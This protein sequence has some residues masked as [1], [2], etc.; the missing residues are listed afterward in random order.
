VIKSKQEEEKKEPEVIKPT[1]TSIVDKK[2]EEPK[3]LQISDVFKAQPKQDPFP[4][5]P[6]KPE[7]KKIGANPF[8]KKEED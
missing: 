7:P 5:K 4:K 3:K 8:A 2:Q 1:L 6:E